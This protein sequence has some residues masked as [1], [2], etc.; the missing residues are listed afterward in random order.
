MGF[1]V[2]H[3]G[4]LYGTVPDNIRTPDQIADVGFRLLVH[5][6]QPAGNDSSAPVSVP[7]MP[8]SP[9]SSRKT[10]L[11]SS[12]SLAGSCPSNA[13]ILLLAKAKALWVASS[14]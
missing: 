11:G 6:T 3:V 12:V 5:P 10:T 4:M 14:C 7:S 1:A 13:S 9:G 8:S 2:V